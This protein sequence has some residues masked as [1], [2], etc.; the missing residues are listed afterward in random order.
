MTEWRKGDLESCWSLAE[1]CIVI[2]DLL[3][4]RLSK[5]NACDLCARQTSNKS[6]QLEN[7]S[8]VTPQHLA[9]PD[10]AW[11]LPLESHM[12]THA[13]TYAY[14]C[15]YRPAKGNLWL[16]NLSGGDVV[17]ERLVIVPDSTKQTKECCA[18]LRS[19]WKWRHRLKNI[20]DRR[21]R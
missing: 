16:C 19:L 18:R 7:R 15:L 14:T 11:A 5:I 4:Y 12:Y 17:A 1:V 2:T 20:S 13:H 9:S 3:F 21:C 6:S 10:T 8:T